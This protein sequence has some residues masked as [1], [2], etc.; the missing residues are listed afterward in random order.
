MAKDAAAKKEE[1]VEAKVAPITVSRFGLEAEFSNAWRVN[2]PVGI[3]PKDTL[4]EEYWQHLSS[5][6]EA[7]DTITVLPDDMA[8]RQLLHV[9]EAGDN[10]AF[11]EELS[12]NEFDSAKDRVQPPSQYR[13]EHAGSHHKWRV[14]LGDRVLKD[15]FATQS[16]AANYA[17]NHQAAVKR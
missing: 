16:L 4:S 10:Y 11:V 1:V 13:V 14:I 17:N 2:V 5:K 6:L 9:A 15:G 7:G 8:Y 3:T 12:L